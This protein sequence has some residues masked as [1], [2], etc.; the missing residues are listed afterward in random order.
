MPY[1]KGSH[2][3]NRKKVC[4][5]CLSKAGST[6]RP[7]ADK[8]KREIEKSVYLNF[9]RNE[10]F[11]PSSVCNGCRRILESQSSENPRPIVPRIRYEPL[12]L[13]LM[14]LPATTRSHQGQKCSC[15]ICRIA[16]H[17]PIKDGKF[18]PSDFLDEEKPSKGRARERP[19]SP[20]KNVKK[21]SECYS[22]LARGK[23]HHCTKA[24]RN[25]NLSDTISPRS[26]AMLA[27]DYIKSTAGATGSIAMT[28]TM[29]GHKMTVTAGPS[30]PLP[31]N[32]VPVETLQHLRAQLGLSFRNTVKA[33][34]VLKKHAGLELE[35]N[36]KKVLN[37]ESH[38]LA[39]FF[40][41]R[42]LTMAVYDV[43]D[44]HYVSIKFLL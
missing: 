35:K 40:E 23:S 36:L 24:T 32:S 30:K 8:L 4:I 38:Q 3:D 6:G 9:F 10:H 5:L 34:Q 20:D 1:V 19:P 28:G 7:L 42:K 29:G 39:D 41:V 37:I 12:S 11:L 27:C 18:E 33:G 13:H 44:E 31:Y 22:V 25:Q 16:S 43:D 14:N 2:E 15:E 17:N 26:R 21:C